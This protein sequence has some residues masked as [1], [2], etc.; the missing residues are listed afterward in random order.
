[1]TEE[2]IKDREELGIAGFTLGIIGLTVSIS[3]ILLGGF[4]TATIISIVGLIFCLKQQKRHPTKKGKKGIIL[5]IIG[6]IVNLIIF[7]YT[8]IVYIIPYVNS[9]VQNGT[10]PAA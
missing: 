7:I 8:L 2:K 4:L 10:F 9:L 5:N 6:L 3:M 1:M